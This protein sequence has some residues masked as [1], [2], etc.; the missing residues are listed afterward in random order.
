MHDL[1]NE[2]NTRKESREYIV[3]QDN[4]S[5]T[6]GGGRGK[7]WQWYG[8]SCQRARVRAWLWGARAGGGAMVVIVTGSSSSSGGSG[9]TCSQPCDA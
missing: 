1:L 4:N 8:P 7:Y 9:S 2:K 6:I 3:L 5:G